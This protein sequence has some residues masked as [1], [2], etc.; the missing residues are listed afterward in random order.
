VID[1]FSLDVEGAEL[2]V[3]KDFP[4]DKYTFKFLT[5]ERP[6]PELIDLL[7]NQGYRQVKK[8]TH[9]G[10]TLWVHDESVALSKEEIDSATI[11]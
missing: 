1:Y 7:Q 5:I 10:E 8:L 2:I 6:K 9:W 3:M 4:F 11:L